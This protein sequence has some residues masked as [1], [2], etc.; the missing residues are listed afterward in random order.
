MFRIVA[1][2]AV[3]ALG[4]C[5]G[6]VKP[7]EAHEFT[8]HGVFSATMSREQAAA[9]CA[10]MAQQAARQAQASGAPGTLPQLYG[11]PPGVLRAALDTLRGCMYAKG[12]RWDTPR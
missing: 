4:A 9:E 3:L 8:P 7:I 2:A 6:N 12:Y 5:A 1:V 10:L 11:T